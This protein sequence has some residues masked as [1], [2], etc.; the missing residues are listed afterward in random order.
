M[1]EVI[2]GKLCDLKSLRDP[3]GVF[4]MKASDG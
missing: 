1:G 4:G 3:E 2:A